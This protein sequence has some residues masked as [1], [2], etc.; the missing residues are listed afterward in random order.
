M[1]HDPTTTTRK[2]KINIKYTQKQSV[3]KTKYQMI[4][5]QKHNKKHKR[6]KYNIIQNTGIQKYQ[7]Q[8]NTNTHIYIYIAT[9][10]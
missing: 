1:S 9:K 2:H 4:K 5:K 3:H 10:V 7:I 8:K 6:A